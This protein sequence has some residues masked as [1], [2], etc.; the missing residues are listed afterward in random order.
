M[1]FC[2]QPSLCPLTDNGDFTH[3]ILMNIN[4]HI[5]ISS[6][7]TAGTEIGFIV[8]HSRN[9]KF[10]RRWMNVR[11]QNLILT[12]TTLIYV[13]VVYLTDLTS[14]LSIPPPD[15]P[16][17]NIRSAPLLFKYNPHHV[18]YRRQ[19]QIQNYVRGSLQGSQRDCSSIGIQEIHQETSQTR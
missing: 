12:Q 18:R 1:Y 19:G 6:C 3:Q 2:L 8:S 15:C 17:I 13:I 16:R 14:P 9:K 11:R 5:C 4:I 7:T 10:Y